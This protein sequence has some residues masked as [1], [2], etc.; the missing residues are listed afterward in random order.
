[1]N[2]NFTEKTRI[3]NLA[4]ELL[5]T[6]LN[7]CYYPDYFTK[8]H[9]ETEKYYCEFKKEYEDSLNDIQKED[10]NT[11]MELD[12]AFSSTGSCMA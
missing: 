12:S 5:C 10:F 9:K 7:N 11:L 2:E 6:I 1:M 8:Y 3:E 4:Y